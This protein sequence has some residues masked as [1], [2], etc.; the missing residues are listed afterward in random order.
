[1]PYRYSIF[2]TDQ[3][4]CQVLR[5][6]FR[7]VAK[8]MEGVTLMTRGRSLYDLQKSSE[9]VTFKHNVISTII[10]TLY[11]QC[12]T[13]NLKYCAIAGFKIQEGY[14]RNALKDFLIMACFL[15]ANFVVFVT[16]LTKTLVHVYYV[17]F[18]FMQWLAR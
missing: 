5:T 13:Y 15:V 18:A 8:E 6:G 1:M 16:I 11:N 17:V 4:Q 2:K 14:V 9:T 10:H 7:T 3:C 12:A